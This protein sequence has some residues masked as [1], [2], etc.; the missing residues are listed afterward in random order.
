M[1]LAKRLRARGRGG[2]NMY[3]YTTQTRHTVLYDRVLTRE[4]SS[5]YRIT[6][7]LHQSHVSLQSPTLVTS[8][9]RE[10]NSKL[11]LQRDTELYHKPGAVYRPL[12]ALSLTLASTD[13]HCE[14][15]VSC[16]CPSSPRSRLFGLRS[17]QHE[18]SVTLDA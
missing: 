6:P 8:A 16:R 7:K 14:K 10:N 5:S 17:L 15:Y 12:T 3:M 4:T 1:T 11:H 9:E 18:S 2:S 13:H